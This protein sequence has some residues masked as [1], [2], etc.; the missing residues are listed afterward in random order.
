MEHMRYVRH[1]QTAFEYRLKRYAHNF[2]ASLPDGSLTP[3]SKIHR[4][5]SCND[6]I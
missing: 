4:N 2:P 6:R 5:R 1:D 3:V